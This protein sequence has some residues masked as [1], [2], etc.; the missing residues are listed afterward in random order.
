MHIP[1]KATVISDRGRSANAGRPDVGIRVLCVDDHAVLVEGLKARFEVD[2]SIGL[3]G[4]LLTA[5]RLLAEVD[6]LRPDVVVLDI[7][8]PGQ[9]VF[10]IADRLHRMRP[11][12]RF[13][14]LSA[15]IKDG[16]LAAA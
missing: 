4:H 15:H 10:E 13:L 1:G 2:G 5:D 7:E 14:F 9:D 6:R 8:M 11:N 3:V 16:Y 12:L